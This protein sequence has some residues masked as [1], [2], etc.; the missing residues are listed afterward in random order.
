METI[1]SKSETKD[2]A[3]IMR[4]AHWEREAQKY[5]CVKYPPEQHQILIAKFSSLTADTDDFHDALVWKYGHTKKGNF[6]ES[7]K[8]I[9]KRTAALWKQYL[10]TDTI[11]PQMT[12]DFW[13]SNSVSFITAAFL[14]HLIHPEKIVII[15]QHNFR[16]MNHHIKK[17]R[18][19]WVGKKLPA[20]WAD[21]VKLTNFVH[22]VSRELKTSS[23]NLDRYL[24][25]H[26]K[27]LKRHHI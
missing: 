5:D 18:T 21:L 19:D 8:C 1:F 24:M 4:S 26:G 13:R 10:K 9:M 14:T 22:Q 20:N 2:I 15:D 25:V 11:V 23:N 27:F 17:V 16:S 7:H 12:F 3:E 6:P